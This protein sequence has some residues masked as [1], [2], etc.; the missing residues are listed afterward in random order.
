MLSRRVQQSRR[1]RHSIWSIF[2]DRNT[3]LNLNMQLGGQ[4]FPADSSIQIFSRVFVCLLH[5]IRLV[6][7]SVRSKRLK[8]AA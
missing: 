7:L 2:S 8:I 1:I 4:R 6:L 3:T 5:C